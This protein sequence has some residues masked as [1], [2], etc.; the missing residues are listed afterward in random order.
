MQC[1]TDAIFNYYT[2]CFKYGGECLIKPLVMLFKSCLI[3]RYVPDFLMLAT[4]VPI[5]K[6]KI[7]NINDSKNYRSIAISNI[8]LKIFDWI[9]I[10]ISG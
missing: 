1:K 2:E 8:L 3:H 10:M 7:G 6:D 4:L 5:L 9:F